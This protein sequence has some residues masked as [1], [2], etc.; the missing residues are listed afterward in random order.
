MGGTS[1]EV[2]MIRGGQA[3][4]TFQRSIKGYPI[5]V[6]SHD[7]HTIGAGGSS[8]ATLDAGGMLSVGPRSAG[9]DPGPA[10]Y[11][12]GGAHATV[13]DANVVLGR[14]NQSHLLGGSLA[15]RA[16]RST[17]AVHREVAEGKR[18]D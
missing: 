14:L 4:K 15:I 18:S 16:E 2:C 8:I 7:I 3:Q 12:K 13:T 6:T 10:C 5:R 9:A 17:Q 1:T 11:A